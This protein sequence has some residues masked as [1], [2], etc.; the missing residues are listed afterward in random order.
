MDLTP[1]QLEA[2][3]EKLAAE[4]EQEL[5]AKF[6]EENEETIEKIAKERLAQ[7]KENMDKLN[8][9]LEEAEKAKAREEEARRKI[10]KERMEAEGKHLELREMQVKELQA[11]LEAAIEANTRLTRDQELTTVLAAVEFKNDTARSL[12]FKE[13]ADQLVK[14]DDTWKHRS[15]ASIKEFVE[16]IYTKDPARDFLFKQKENSGTEGPNGRRTPAEKDRPANLKGLSGPE[17]LKLAEKGLL[18]QFTM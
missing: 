7:M 11:Q 16:K 4:L 3:R 17:L 15:G 12:A 14:V 6:V 9:K 13:I 2:A 18:G 8:K 5:K 10:E 1:E